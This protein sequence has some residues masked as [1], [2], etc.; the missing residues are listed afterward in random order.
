MDISTDSMQNKVL[1]ER[2]WEI[3]RFGFTGGVCFAVDFVALVF[4]QELCGFKNLFGGHGI[5]LS[6][7]FAYAV[8]LSVH[9]FLA[10]F[11]V[12]RGH[13]VKSGR[14]HALAGSLFVLCYAIGFGFTVLG[15]WIGSRLFGFDYRFVKVV[16]TRIV[17]FWN[18]I[19]QKLFVFRK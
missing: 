18:Y 10:A 3:F 1:K 2:F 8:S 4:F 16:V 15:M 7:T 9:Y 17:M 13:K 19:G 5:V 14:D 6:T 11:W 12:F